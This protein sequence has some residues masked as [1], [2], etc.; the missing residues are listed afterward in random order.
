VCAAWRHRCCAPLY[1]AAPATP[2]L[3][4]PPPPPAPPAQ[5]LDEERH[6]ILEGHRDLADGP[7][8]VRMQ[9]RLDTLLR[10]FESTHLVFNL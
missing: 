10:R 8:A 1:R 6:A 2:P 3:P 9:E 7:A 4:P 5:A